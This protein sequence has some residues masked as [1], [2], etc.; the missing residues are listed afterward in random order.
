MQRQLHKPAFFKRDLLL[1]RSDFR[2][3]VKFR[4]CCSVSATQV[5]QQT[6]HSHM[7]SWRPPA[8]PRTHQIGKTP[9]VSFT[10]L[11]PSFPS[12]LVLMLV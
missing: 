10:V 2:L 3:V 6:P 8:C 12:A 5:A 4:C 9:G 7:A 1:L 11:A